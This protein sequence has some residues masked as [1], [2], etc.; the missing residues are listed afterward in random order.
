M[1]T[2]IDIYNEILCYNNNEINYIIDVNNIIWFKFISISKILEYKS[3]KDVLRDH[4]NKEHK[5]QLKNIKRLVK[6]DI[7]I[8]QPDTVYINENGL[9]SLLIKSR[10]KKA[11]NF[12]LWLINTA[13]PKLREFGKYEVDKKTKIKLDNLNKKI[14]ILKNSNKKLKNNMT[15]NKYPHGYHFYIIKDDNMY[16]IGY[17]KDLNKRLSVYNTGKAN[18]SEY[19]YFKKTDCAKEI[20]ECMKAL[21]NKYIYKSNKEFYNCSLNKILK[22]VKKCLTIESKCSKCKDILNNNIQ[23]LG[24][25]NNI[26]KELINYYINEYNNIIHS[27]TIRN[28]I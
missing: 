15:K 18:K 3:T 13:L 8:K 23:Q 7:K 4:V 26:I 19:V 21:L 5:I 28:K 25:G 11:I 24:G 16:K 9:Y 2:I 17:T 27:F 10:M 1:N 14:K 22:E 12:Q 6:D 20:E